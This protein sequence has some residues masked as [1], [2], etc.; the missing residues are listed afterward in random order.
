MSQREEP[1]SLS[2]ARTCGEGRL[3]STSL[4]TNSLAS[5]IDGLRC[6]VYSERQ[7]NVDKAATLTGQD[8]GQEGH[9][10]SKGLG[11]LWS[12]TLSWPQAPHAAP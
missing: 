4:F 2:Q 11:K 12:S 3:H 9:E 10:L 5:Y 1:W 7:W 6:P 8:R